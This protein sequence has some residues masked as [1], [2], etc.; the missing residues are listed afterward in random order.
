MPLR[1]TSL[2]IL[3]TKTKENSSVRDKTRK[4]DG[5][6][7]HIRKTNMTSIVAANCDCEQYK[8]A[9]TTIIIESYFVRKQ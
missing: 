2:S 3:N 8:K 1:V 7:E 4:N 5:R 9:E 6:K